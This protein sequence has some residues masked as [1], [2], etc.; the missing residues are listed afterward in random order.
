MVGWGRNE[1][2]RTIEEGCE[3]R[4][5]KPLEKNPP[6]TFESDGE[7][8]VCLVPCHREGAR[9]A[10]LMSRKAGT[11]SS[12]LGSDYRPSIPLEKSSHRHFVFIASIDCGVLH[13]KVPLA[14]DAEDEQ[15]SS[16]GREGR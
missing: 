14:R 5:L 3:S 11:G 12:S 4:S 7:L 1:G 13:S 8:P 6:G 15:M 2:T 16:R 9:S 10:C